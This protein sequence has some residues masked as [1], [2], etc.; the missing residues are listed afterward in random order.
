MPE[1]IVYKFS[2]VT[3]RLDISNAATPSA[4]IQP[5]PSEQTIFAAF[6]NAGA[7][8]M[9]VATSS[10]GADPGVMFP[11]TSQ[12]TVNGFMLPASMTQPMIVQVPSQGFKVAALTN[13]ATVTQLFITPVSA[14]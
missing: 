6:L 10:V 14:A 3:T 7:A 8:P 1:S 9:A 11:S 2:G 12:N 5:P 13:S 4:L